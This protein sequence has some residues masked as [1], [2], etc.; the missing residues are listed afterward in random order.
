MKK[1]HKRL[2]IETLENREFMAADISAADI[3]VNENDGQAIFTVNLDEKSRRLISVK[4][5]TRPDTA[6]SADFKSQK[7]T[8][9]FYPGETSKQIKVS[10]IDDALI[11]SLEKFNLR[12]SSAKN[13]RIADGTAICSI[14]DNDIVVPP[15]TDP[16]TNTGVGLTGA[17]GPRVISAPVGAIIASGTT[18]QVNSIIS[19]APEGATLYIKAGVYDIGIQPKNNQK[20]IFEYGAILKSSTRQFAIWSLA[21]G[22]TIDNATID[23]YKPSL[24]GSSLGAGT[25]WTVRNCEVRNS[26]MGGLGFDGGCIIENNWV[27]DCDQLGIHQGGSG[28]ARNIVF[29][30]NLIERNNLLYKFDSYWEAGGSKFW[31]TD[32]ATIE[33]NEFRYNGGIGLWVDGDC[34]NFTIRNNYCHHNDQSGIF[35]EISGKALIEGNLCT[36]NGLKYEDLWPEGAGILVKTSRDV[37]VRNNTCIGNDFGIAI[38]SQ[39]EGY[40]NLTPNLRYFVSGIDVYNNTLNNNQRGSGVWDDGS[41]W[42]DTTNDIKWDNILVPRNFRLTA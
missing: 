38:T 23:G 8:L 32:G 16:P 2:N 6:T 30:N 7:G 26:T 31:Q 13:A 18:S 29:R 24:Q 28:L 15:P 5:E 19:N 42:A 4:Y 35:Y 41:S 3:S 21:T 11:E 1:K 40:S 34:L 17:V 36:N 20:I 9:Y 14:L 10:L 37:I 33:N 22:V 39:D 12:L 27:H 25:D